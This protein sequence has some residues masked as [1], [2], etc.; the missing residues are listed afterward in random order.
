MTRTLTIQTAHGSLH[1]LFER[2]DETHG[3][4][5]LIRT[6]HAPIDTSIAAELVGRGYAVLRCEL[7]TT[8]EAQFA[9]A[10]LNVPR[11][12]Q[13]LIDILDLIRRDGDMLDLPLTLL[14]SGDSSPATIRA[15]AQRDNQVKVV[16]C[17][18]GLID[19]AGLQA[20]HLLAAPL[21]M[22]F[23]VDDEIGPTAFQRAASHLDCQYASK[24]LEV[25]EN[26][27]QAVVDWIRRH[28]PA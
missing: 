8:Q 17:H 27:L 10:T 12:S 7:L 2:P 14:A 6:H 21:L 20:L 4:V 26:P 9:D 18:G 22:L 13:R 19:R 24:V 1:N 25:G 11:L 28:S 16:A 5:L 15:A 23:D 3:L